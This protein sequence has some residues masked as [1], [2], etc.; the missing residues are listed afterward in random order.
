VNAPQLAA[1]LRSG[2]PEALPELLDAHGDRFFCCWRLLRNRENAQMTVRD[3]L[4]AATAQIGRLFAANG[5]ACGSSHRAAR[6]S[7]GVRRFRMPMPMSRRHSAQTAARR[8]RAGRQ[9]GSV[10]ISDIHQGRS[11]NPAQAL[12]KLEW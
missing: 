11:V 3:A 9:A 7:T 8:L 12:T 10:R 2:S 6:N 1:A 4:V 5:P